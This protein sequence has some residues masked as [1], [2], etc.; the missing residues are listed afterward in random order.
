MGAEPTGTKCTFTLR[1]GLLLLFVDGATV[2]FVVEVAACCVVDGGSDRDSSGWASAAEGEAAAAEV[3]GV[4]ADD[5]SLSFSLDDM[6][7]LSVRGLMSV[8]S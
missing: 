8:A 6:M 7:S 1:E 2:D 5:E 4:S 3:L